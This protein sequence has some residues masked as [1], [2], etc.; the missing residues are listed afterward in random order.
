MNATIARGPVAR[1]APGV[2][3]AGVSDNA[4]PLFR[5]RRHIGT[6]SRTIMVTNPARISSR[7]IAQPIPRGRNMKRSTV[8]LTAFFA[9]FL[10][11]AA[12]G[13]G[14]A[15][16]TPRTLMS[17]ADFNESRKAI[18]AETRTVFAGCRSQSGTAR[19]ICK[20][21]ARAEE[22]VKLADLSARYHGTVAA[23]EDSRQARVK[24]RFDL[25]KAR[26][27]SQSGEARVECLRTAR[28][29]HG[30]ALEAKLASN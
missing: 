10:S 26:C 2:L 23:A 3:L 8:Y 13:I 1:P 5:T 29:D 7:R 4:L 6:G 15:V 18:E 27:G 25:A 14:A 24:A 9:L 11:V 16:D 19:D 21:E 28:E 30:R 20:A 17:R 22:R 12:I